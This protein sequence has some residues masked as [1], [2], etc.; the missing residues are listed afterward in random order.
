MEIYQDLQGRL[1]FTNFE[2]EI[3]MSYSAQIWVQEDSI[4]RFFNMSLTTTFQG[5]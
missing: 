3:A 1:T 5:R 2:V 4:S